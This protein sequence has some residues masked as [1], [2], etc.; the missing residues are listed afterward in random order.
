MPPQDLEKRL[1]HLSSLRAAVEDQVAKRIIGQGAAVRGVLAAVLARG[2][3]LLVGVPGLAK[4]MLARTVAEALE[5]SFRRVQFT[6]DLMPSDVT[7]TNVIQER[8]DGRRAFEFSPG[9]LFAN[10]VLAD[11]INR[12][13]PK[14]QA[15]L[16][17]AMQE[18]QV[19]SGQVSHALPD[20]F[21][22][23]ATQ[24]PIEQEGTYELPEAQLDRFL[25]ALYLDYPTLG[26][27]EEI[28]AAGAALEEAPVDRV[29]TRKDLLEAQT[30]VRELPVSNYLVSYA[31]RL[32]RATRPQDELAPPFVR[33]MVD[34]GV[35]PRGG[36]YLL[37]VARAFAGLDGRAAVGTGD[38]KEAFA[39]A[40]R[41]RLGLNFQAQAE[42]LDE[43]AILARVLETV[44]EP[45]LP[46][47]A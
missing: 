27:E 34:W 22:V 32:V 37:L 44:P 28:Y 30:L 39:P 29:V 41:H 42:G 31:A 11:E 17:E 47:Y 33:E 9:P 21:L 18:R 13:P 10:V 25:L 5:L 38:L 3:T 1:A 15:A 7:G 2:H 43:A 36:Q 8:E 40:L 6:P 4:T 24:N 19:T 14:T 12:A 26:E 35:G 45:R 23:L 20:P 46:K 16:L